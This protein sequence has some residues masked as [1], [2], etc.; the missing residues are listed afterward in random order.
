M[1][2]LLSLLFVSVAVASASAQAQ[3]IALNFEGGNGST[4]TAPTG[5]SA[6]GLVN[7]NQWNELTG[8]AATDSDLL[9]TDGTTGSSVTGL[10]VTYFSYDGYQSGNT[11]LGNLLNGYL[12]G[13]GASAGLSDGIITVTLSSIPFAA[14]DV[15]AYVGADS[16]GRESSSYINTVADSLSF[17]TAVVGATTFSVNSDPLAANPSVTTLLFTNVTGSSFT[18]YQNGNSNNS[19]TGL[20]ALEVVEVPEPSS[21]AL[22]TMGLSSL[23][24]LGWILRRRA[25][26]S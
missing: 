5:V 24:L 15:Y 9:E 18:Y 1:S 14:Y 3:I 6:P 12:D 17:T 23:A 13:N 10:D 11:N 22:C 26:L 16:N 21:P 25:S 8:A 19:G 20:M 7:A 4:V 2:K